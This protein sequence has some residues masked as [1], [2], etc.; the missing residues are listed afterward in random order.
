MLSVLLLRFTSSPSDNVM[1]LKEEKR[2]LDDAAMNNDQ[3][4]R[5]KTLV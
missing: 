2:K 5:E 1:L 4:E 3:K